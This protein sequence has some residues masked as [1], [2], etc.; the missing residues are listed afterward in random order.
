MKKLYLIILSVFLSIACFAQYVNTIRVAS[1]TTAFSDNIPIG[2]QVYCVSNKSLYTAIA[3]IGVAA[4]IS[5]STAS[6]QLT[7]SG[8]RSVNDSIAY[9]DITSLISTQTAANQFTVSS[10]SGNL[11]NRI[12]VADTLAVQT[13]EYSVAFSNVSVA[14]WD[15][16]EQ[17]EG[18]I[19]NGIDYTDAMISTSLMYFHGGAI[20]DTSEPT[21]YLFEEGQYFAIDPPANADHTLVDIATR[22]TVSTDYLVSAISFNGTNTIIT[23]NG[24]VTGDSPQLKNI[25]TSYFTNSYWNLTGTDNSNKDKLGKN[26]VDLTFNTTISEFD[27]DSNVVYAKHCKIINDDGTITDIGI[28][29]NYNGRGWRLPEYVTAAFGLSGYNSVDLSYSGSSTGTD[30]ATGGNA[31]AAGTST[32]ASG[33]NSTTMGYYSTASGYKSVVIGDHNKATQTNSF[34]F[35]NYSVSTGSQSFTI[36][37]RDTASGMQSFS[38]GSYNTV[39]GTASSIFGGRDHKIFTNA[40]YSTV[41]GGRDNEIQTT[42]DYSGILAGKANDIGAGSDYCALIG[43]LTNSIASGADNTIVLGGSSISATESN[44]VYVP[45]LISNS[46]IKIGDNANSAT[47]S[48]V[49]SLRYRADANNSWLEISMQTGAST[50]AWVVIKTNTW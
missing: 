24:S 48:N 34:S 44:T 43:G 12:Q 2:T 6:L 5:T 18:Y 14:W 38:I 37:D 23:I 8:L 7:N 10:G 11:T 36:G 25:R 20:A 9:G 50:Y 3:P 33:S 13:Y 42:S 19:D 41:V 26:S 30:G 22:S 27:P 17:E 16:G 45:K 47:A 29:L 28:G 31:F 4:S 49:G 15:T 39:D 1:T 21:D 46:S 32:T 35:G 40:T